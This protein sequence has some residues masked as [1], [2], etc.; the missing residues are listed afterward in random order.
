[1]GHG[2]EKF[3]TPDLQKNYARVGVKEVAIGDKS[4]V[5]QSGEVCGMSGPAEYQGLRSVEISSVAKS[6]VSR[7]S[8]EEFLGV[9]LE[10]TAKRNLPRRE[11]D[12]RT[13]L[14]ERL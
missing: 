1:M 10:S 14:H 5:S 4:E 7:N 12:L 8:A 6:R 13:H 3:A 11:F 2:K 9:D